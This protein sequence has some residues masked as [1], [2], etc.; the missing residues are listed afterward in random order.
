MLILS[1]VTYQAYMLSVFQS[2]QAQSLQNALKPP[3]SL[4]QNHWLI[5]ASA[6]SS[7]SAFGLDH[8]QRCCGLSK[9]P[10]MAHICVMLRAWALCGGHMQD[11]F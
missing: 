3:A 10:C 6:I 2:G 4:Y 9:L 11:F 5:G 1:L 8:M 7:C